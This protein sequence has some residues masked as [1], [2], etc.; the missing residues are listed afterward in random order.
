MKR[1]RFHFK[2]M[3]IDEICQKRH[4]FI[5]DLST[6]RLFSTKVERQ[7]QIALNYVNWDKAH[8]SNI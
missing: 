4:S 2:F 1:E 7:A 3:K 5:L 6:H 8:K